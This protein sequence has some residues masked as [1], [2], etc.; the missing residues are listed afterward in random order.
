MEPEISDVKMC[1]KSLAG[2]KR[3]LRP[4]AV[5]ALEQAL[6]ARLLTWCQAGPT[7]RMSAKD[8]VDTTR[9]ALGSC[10]LREADA[11]RECVVKL[12]AMAKEAAVREKQTQLDEALETLAA[13]LSDSNVRKLAAVAEDSAGLKFSAS[14]ARE[15]GSYYLAAFGSGVNLQSL[16]SHSWSLFQDSMQVETGVGPL[17]CFVSLFFVV[18][19]ESDRIEPRVTWVRLID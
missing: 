18:W 7:A 8:L 9:L 2:W 15:A 16:Q 1:A 12:D 11:L 5:A 13:D 14:V 10:V 6:G 19:I 17:L 4:A 3:T